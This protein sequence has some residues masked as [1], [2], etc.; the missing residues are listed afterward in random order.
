M[1]KLSK[2]V[3]TPN[4]FF[5]DAVEKKKRF[6]KD[7]LSGVGFNKTKDERVNHKKTPYAQADSDYVNSYLDFE[8]FED[9]IFYE[10]FHGKGMSGNPYAIFKY[11]LMQPKYQ[12]YSHVWAINDKAAVPSEYRKLKNV[13]FV[14]VHSEE[15]LKAIS[16]SKY[17][18]NNTTFP[19]Y[20][21]RKKEQVYVNTW[22][23]V[24]FK[25]LGKDMLG[26]KGQHKN[27]QRNFLQATHLVMPNRYTSDKI[28]KS[29]DIDGIYKGDVIES[30]YP[31]ADLTLNADT[32]LLR[33]TLDIPKDKK[34]VLI[35]P[36]WR[37]NIG[38]VTNQAEKIIKDIE[39][40]VSNIGEEYM[41][42]FRGHALIKKYIKE[43]DLP[44]NIV[45][46]HIDSN[47]FLSVTDVLIS[48]YSSI[49]FDF[50]PLKRSLIIYCHDYESYKADRGTYFDIGDLPGEKCWTVNEV[51]DA[52]SLGCSHLDDKNNKA[53]LNR[54]CPYDDGGAT[55]RVVDAVFNGC[56]ND[57]VSYNDNEKKNILFYCGGFQ[58]N[59]ITSSAINLINEIDYQK[60]NVVVVDSG[61]KNALRSQNLS[62]ITNKAKIVY[63]CGS[64][65]VRESDS[66]KIKKFYAGRHSKPKL[67]R[68]IKNIF[69]REYERLFGDLEFHAVVDF[70]GYVKFW[71]VLFCFA[72]DARKIIYQHNDMIAESNKKI[73]GIYKH[74]NN[75]NTIF[76][77]Y[78]FFDRVISVS[79][80]TMDL[81]KVGL[82][83][84]I[85]YNY[86]NLS[87]VTNC[88]NPKD[89]FSKSE[90]FDRFLINNDAYFVER[91]DVVDNKV[92]SIKGV[93]F[94]KDRNINFVTIG[95]MSPEKRHD[96]LLHAFKD[97]CSYND[98]A[99]L[100]I[101]G[102]GDLEN[103][104]VSLAKSLDI[105]DKVVFT[106][107]LANP[108]ALLS[109]CDCF[110][111]SSDHEGQPM[112]LL[113]AL[114]LNKSIIAT[115]ITGSASVLGNDFGLLVDNSHKGLAKGMCDFINKGI[116]SKE[117]DYE[118]Y[119][120]DSMSLFYQEVCGMDFSKERVYG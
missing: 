100:Y 92:L 111:L 6:F 91:N 9:K 85:G 28:M 61:D 44:C 72:T 105:S 17:L 42:F 18:I 93:P 58:N 59:G 69:K 16:D 120:N 26:E 2:L 4:K 88:I 107:Q 67:Q 101:V 23:G 45:P 27:I 113:E 56:K 24:P 51:I 84:T 106:G 20:F 15:Y 47:Q 103:E 43:Q 41:F 98:N 119:V 114:T 110:V 80:K 94:P 50:L 97:V 40:I 90:K 68:D 38:G 11:L 102:S 25:T 70:S 1:S 81:N 54:Y 48:D 63:R 19:T 3:E 36:T 96:K 109:M 21:Q 65:N 52:I 89:I 53:L 86:D 112:V 74:K 57:V 118:A 99:Y 66:G 31:R 10:S 22:H 8:I 39:E 29:H 12:N 75:L 46:D 60:Y 79:K 32:E 55:E 35:A 5:E 117:F 73:N 71:T 95:R 76:Y 30:G 64:M 37:G 77:L 115:N 62:R 49:I 34:I 83:K 104:I 87:Y 108:Y 14:K 33:K 7:V 82:Y 116:E 13:E 78:R